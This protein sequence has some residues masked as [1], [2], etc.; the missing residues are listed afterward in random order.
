MSVSITPINRFQLRDVRPGLEK[1]R[2]PT[3]FAD[4]DGTARPSCA[5]D[6]GRKNLIQKQDSVTSDDFRDVTCVDPLRLLKQKLA[7]KNLLAHQTREHQTL[8]VSQSPQQHRTTTKIQTSGTEKKKKSSLLGEDCDKV[9]DETT[10][11][12]ATPKCNVPPTRPE[13]KIFP[14]NAKSSEGSESH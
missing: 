5:D 7:Q 6:E 14:K 3:E 11:S 1:Q 9:H 13:R 12:D 8:L 4:G 10:S 2:I